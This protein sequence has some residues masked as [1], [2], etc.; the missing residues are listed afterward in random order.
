MAESVF[1]FCRTVVVVDVFKDISST[2][3]MITQK[4]ENQKSEGYT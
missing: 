3:W 1:L 4:V 2:T